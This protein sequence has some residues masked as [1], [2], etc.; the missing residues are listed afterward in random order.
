MY[1]LWQRPGSTSVFRVDNEVAKI[2]L[3]GAHELEM[4]ELVAQARVP[5]VLLPL[6]AFRDVPAG[7]STLVFPYLQPCPVVLSV[8]EFAPFAY[9]LLEV[10]AF[11]VA[12]YSASYIVR[13]D[14]LQA[15]AVL[16]DNDI[17]HGDVKAHNIM[18]LPDGRSVLIDFNSSCK[19]G[20]EKALG[21]PAW[22]APELVE[23]WR[24]PVMT[25]ACDIYS[26][27]CA[28]AGLM[29]RCSSRPHC[30]VPYV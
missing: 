30:I 6:R 20:R 25:P 1:P 26:L 14:S 10:F 27:G 2:E 29:V 16:H 5:H 28:L 8:N 7:G 18:C 13:F 11:A 9:P 12:H 19:A 17:V 23:G 15:L 24:I 22:M 21:T 4:L 3:A